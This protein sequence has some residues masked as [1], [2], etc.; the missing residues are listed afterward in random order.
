[1][2]ITRLY[3]LAAVACSAAHAA[4]LPEITI[5][6]KK[7]TTESLTSTAD[8]S[9]IISSMGPGIIF[10][11]KPGAATAQPWIERGTDGLANLLGVLADE[12][13]N[14]LW[15]CSFTI[16]AP[17]G[18]PKPPSTLHAFQLS[19][20][21]PKGHWPL[22][23]PGGLCNDV[24]I[25][26]D[27]T[28]YITDTENMEIASLAPQAKA[29]KV[30]AGDGQFGAKGGV[31]DGIAVVRGHVVV[32][33]LETAKLFSVPIGADG[34]AGAVVE[35]KLDGALKNPDG[36]RSF[37]DDGLLLVDAADGGR[38]LRVRLSGKH[39]ES[40]RLTTI[41]KGFPNGTNALTVVGETAYVLGAQFRTLDDPQAPHVPYTAT[42]VH[43][44]K[45]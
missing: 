42:P 35:I 2:K 26:P 17:A 7:L 4:P 32:N 24:A 3:L 37:G 44:G 13:S 8:G 31:L 33:A 14:T 9:V 28:A 6:G 5:P 36:Q 25:G 30:W 15:A 27:G 16:D 12:R 34:K 23:T 1:M 18:A 29:L 45:P 43:V 21:A 20:G 10:R 22:P 19:N 41:R 39:F 40:G 38:L 11:A